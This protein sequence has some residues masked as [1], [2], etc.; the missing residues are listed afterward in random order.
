MLLI[1]VKYQVWIADL[2][3]MKVI[4]LVRMDISTHNSLINSEHT[5]WKPILR[6]IDV[7]KYVCSSVA[8]RRMH[9]EQQLG[10][11]TLQRR[12][13]L[14][15]TFLTLRSGASNLPP[16][17]PNLL[18]ILETLILVPFAALSIFLQKF[19]RS[20][21]SRSCSLINSNYQQMFTHL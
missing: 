12:A 13:S 1:I 3:Q 11:L 4:L 8:S 21:G 19:I 7:T 2:A 9:S 20:L 17:L 5:R 14:H 16:F 6:E 18:R 15:R 10:E